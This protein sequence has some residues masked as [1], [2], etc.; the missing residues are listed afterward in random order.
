MI[1][2]EKYCFFF[3]GQIYFLN[4][5]KLRLSLFSIR[6][7]VKTFI[8]NCVYDIIMSPAHFEIKNKVLRT[9]K[10]LRIDSYSLCL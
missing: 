2:L 10:R 9:L 6:G 3:I 5:S 4:I 7:N 1:L 8:E